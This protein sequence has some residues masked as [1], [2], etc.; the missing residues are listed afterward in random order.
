MFH[1]SLSNNQRI[2]RYVV[3]FVMNVHSSE[4]ANSIICDLKFA[5]LS[6]H[7][8]LLQKLFLHSGDS[9]SILLHQ[10]A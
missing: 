5:T 3:E 4:N 8:W 1:F 6:W 10:S 2:Y 9:S 7:F